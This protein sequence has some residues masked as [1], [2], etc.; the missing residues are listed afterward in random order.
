MVGIT[1]T[2]DARSDFSSE[3]ARRTPEGPWSLRRLRRGLA[4]VIP[5]GRPAVL[6]DAGPL[7]AGHGSV[8]EYDREV[9]LILAPPGRAPH[10]PLAAPAEAK[11]SMTRVSDLLAQ[12]LGVAAPR[13]LPR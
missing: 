7:A 1:V 4:A 11:L 2:L 6:V 12:W 10:A 9:P 13:T 5:G 3:V 8:Y